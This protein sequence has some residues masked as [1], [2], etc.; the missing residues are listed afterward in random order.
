[1]NY[2]EN[3]DKRIIEYFNILEPEFPG[4]LNDFI[5]TKELL[6]QRYISKIWSKVELVVR[7]KNINN[8]VVNS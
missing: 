5:N 6:S 2:L 3:V 1:M 4:W 7:V 8:A